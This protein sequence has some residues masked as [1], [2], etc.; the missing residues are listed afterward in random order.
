M[1]KFIFLYVL[2]CLVLSCLVLSCL[3]LSCP[4]LSCVLFPI[5]SCPVQTPNLSLSACLVF[6][7]NFLLSCEYARSARLVEF[8]VS[9][10]NNQRS[11]FKQQTGRFY[12][13]YYLPWQVIGRLYRGY[14]L[15][16]KVIGRLYKSYY[17]PWQVI[18][19]LY[20]SYYLP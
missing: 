1:F 15:P 12:W 10:T 4:V 17:L 7:N 3:V 16:W 2:S 14:Y 8:Q 18:S 13:G 19:R 9:S 6:H 5:L 11:T 20:R